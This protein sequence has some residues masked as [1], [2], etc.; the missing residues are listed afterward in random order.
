LH[1]QYCLLQLVEVFF[2][3]GDAEGTDERGEE[4]DVFRVGGDAVGVNAGDCWGE[5]EGLKE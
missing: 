1:E 5:G 4:L 2:E 3:D